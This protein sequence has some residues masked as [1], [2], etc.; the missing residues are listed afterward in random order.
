MAAWSGVRAKRGMFT[1]GTNGIW[2]AAARGLAARGAALSI[3][4]RDHARG[5]EAAAQIGVAGG[6]R[7]VDVLLADLSSQASVRR[8]AAAGAERHPPPQRLL[9]HACD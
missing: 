3:V 7:P 5:E 1:G 9:K 6:G 8:L 4:A 2:L